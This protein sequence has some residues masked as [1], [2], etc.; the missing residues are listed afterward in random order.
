M[1]KLWL[2]LSPRYEIIMQ[3]QSRFQGQCIIGNTLQK[4]LLGGIK[5]CVFS[6]ASVFIKTMLRRS[7]SWQTLWWTEM[8]ISL[9]SKTKNHIYLSKTN[10]LLHYLSIYLST[11]IY[12]FI[13][14][15][16]FSRG[17]MLFVYTQVE[18]M[19]PAKHPPLWQHSLPRRP[20]AHARTHTQALQLIPRPTLRSYRCRSFTLN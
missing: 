1:D 6:A 10:Q 14:S 13:Q 17:T 12:L 4:C 15:I 18:M 11:Y 16:P 19:S 8:L 20:P 3:G 7:R 9:R 5:E 2:A